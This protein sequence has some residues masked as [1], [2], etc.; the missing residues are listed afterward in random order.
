[1]DTPRSSV[2]EHPDQLALWDVQRNLPT[3]PDQAGQRSSRRYWWQCPVADDHVWQAASASVARSLGK[4]FRGCPACAGRQV[5]TTNSLQVLFPD[6]ADQWHPTLNGDVTASD[7]PAGRDKHAW[8]RCTEGPDHEWCATISSRTKGDLGCPACSGKQVSV[9]NSVASTP[10][11]E[12]WHP[13]RNLPLTAED[14]IAGT[15]KKVWWQC[16]DDPSH[17]WAA[18]GANR[19][20]G[21]GC[22][23]CVEHLRSTLEICLAYEL[24][25]FLPGLDLAGDKVTVDGRIRHVD[26]LVRDLQ[27][28]IEVDGRYHHDGTEDADR[29]KSAQLETAGWH[30]IRL[31]EHPLT[32]LSPHDVQLPDN[33][34]TKQTADLVLAALQADGWVDGPAVEAYLQ[35]HEPAHLTAA[36]QEVARRRPG[37]PIR[38]PGT[39]PGPD[40]ATR[41]EN[42]YT[43]LLAFVYREG[44]AVVPDG[45][46]EGELTL[47]R[48]VTDQRMRHRRDK[49]QP[50]RTARLEAVPGWVWDVAEAAWED[51]FSHLQAFLAREGHL[52]V[53][54]HHVEPD[55]YPLGSW[56]RSHRRRGGRRTITDDQQARLEALPGWSYD[57]PIDQHWER[58][59]AALGA[60]AAEHG[61]T[62]APEAGDLNLRSWV[63]LQR[64]KYRQ[65]TLTSDR[66]ERLERVPGWS[67]DPLAD[68]WEHGFDTLTRFVARAGTALVPR[69]HC[70]DGYPLGSWVGEQRTSRDSLPTDRHTRLQAIAGWSWDPHADR[71]EHMFTLLEQFVAREGHAGVPTGHVE[72]GESLASWVIRHRGDYKHGRVPEDRAARLEALPGWMWD[73]RDARWDAGYRALQA[74]AERHGHARVPYS[75]KVGDLQ[76][77]AWVVSQRAARRRGDLAD[78]RTRRLQAVP[79]WVWD[80]RPPTDTGMLRLP[81]EHEGAGVQQETDDL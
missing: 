36:L 11:A 32:P 29:R 63:A 80:G 66:T 43:A 12:E 27:L 37:K 69:D 56:V 54:A 44:H 77:G 15:G 39:P 67:W 61:H 38:I 7:V 10:L 8:W 55:G 30:V 72:D 78:E 57:S 2:A 45:H 35:R 3:T 76:L 13:T 26:L 42:H 46:L 81:F 40:R 64:Q 22:P 79:R 28:V 4:G 17:E 71:W 51:G 73:T 50:E 52:R 34:T 19:V 75:H 49:L 9:T 47:G 65:G 62:H 20:R 59:Y 31:R 5:S 25:D 58:A 18:T 74:F 68:A 48:W 6:I 33:P 24:A 70:E 14:L 16:A 60:F 1:M 41:W 53:E 21:R 23:W